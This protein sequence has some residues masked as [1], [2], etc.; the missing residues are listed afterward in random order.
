MLSSGALAVEASAEFV[1]AEF[2][3]C[4]I[5]QAVREGAARCIKED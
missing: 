2:V 3:P 4:E 1:R 5:A